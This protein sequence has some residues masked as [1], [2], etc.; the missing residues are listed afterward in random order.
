MR[1]LMLGNSL[2]TANDLPALLGEMLDA[3]V[4]VH[5]RGGARLAEHLN[6]TTR[7]GGMTQCALA[8]GGWDFVVLQESSNGPVA[9]CARF[10]E[11]AAQLC[12]QVRGAGATPVLFA[13]WAY[14]PDCP[15][16]AKMGMTRNK[17]HQL[18]AD[19]YREAAR[20]S[21]A[22]K[23]ACPLCQLADVGTAFYEHPDA[24]TLYCTDGVHPSEEGTR[25]AARVIA[26]TLQEIQTTN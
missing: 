25:L 22:D 13:T 23:G 26:H 9:H 6:P 20:I 19:A 2:T 3:E 17:M 15:K 14:A 12:M 16:L 18:L 1:I 10:L 7:L 11:A 5:A 8:E 4:V 24:D 21:N